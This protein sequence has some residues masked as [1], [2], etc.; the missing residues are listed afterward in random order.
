M[1]Q[2]LSEE[3]SA[4]ASHQLRRVISGDKQALK[5]DDTLRRAGNRMRPLQAAAWP[6]V[7]DHVV[8]GMI[9]GPNP[10]WRAQRYGHDPDKSFVSACM[11]LEVPHCYDDEDCSQALEFM[12][13]RHLRYVPVT[14]HKEHFVGIVSLDEIL[15]ALDDA[16]AVGAAQRPVH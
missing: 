15:T 9:E 12:L 8:I 4:S 7:K 14:D 16:D 3:R 5:P 6:V 2:A 10:D 1:P 13:A 11:H